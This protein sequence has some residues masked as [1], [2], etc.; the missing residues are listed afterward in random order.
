M[1]RS[2]VLD[3]GATDAL[4]DPQSSGRS[5]VHAAL[6]AAHRLGRSVIVPSVVLAESYRDRS[7]TQAFDSLLART[8][9]LQLRDTD[10][11]LARLVGGLLGA[12]GL[13][14]EDI[15]DAH[16]VA[17]ALEAGG[18]VCL[19]ADPYD[20]ERI[21]AGSPAVVVVDIS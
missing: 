7:R 5:K 19:T 8:G 10:R 11:W 3:T 9:A 14:T 12:S 13:G 21:S 2:L 17:V 6:E 18:G 16:V 15:V 4:L 20:L 1:T